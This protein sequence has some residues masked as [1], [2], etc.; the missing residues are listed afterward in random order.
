MRDASAHLDSDATAPA[1]A[2]LATRSAADAASWSALAATVDNWDKCRVAV[3]ALAAARRLHRRHG[4]PKLSSNCLSAAASSQ[5]LLAAVDAQLQTRV[6]ASSASS[7]SEQVLSTS[8]L[9]AELLSASP[10]RDTDRGAR[11]CHSIEACLR[12]M[13]IK[14]TDG[15]NDQDGDEHQS[16]LDYVISL[17]SLSQ[18]KN[19]SPNGPG[20]RYDSAERYLQAQSA[21]HSEDFVRDL[22]RDLDRLSTN[23]KDLQAL[24]AYG[25][26]NFEDVEVGRDG[27]RLRLRLTRKVFDYESLD[28]ESSRRLLDGALIIF[29]CPSTKKRCLGIVKEEDRRDL[30]RGVLRAAVRSME[31]AEFLFEER[32]RVLLFESSAYLEAF[33][34]FAKGL[35]RKSLP[36][37]DY[38][39]D[40]SVD[41]GNKMRCR[42]FKVKKTFVRDLFHAAPCDKKTA[43][44]VYYSLSNPETKDVSKN[45]SL[46][47]LDVLDSAKILDKAQFDAVRDSLQSEVGLVQGPPGTGKSFV[48]KILLCALLDN[49]Q[50]R[51]GPVLVVSQTNKCLD[52]LLESLLNR[53]S[54]IVRLGSRCTSDKLEGHRLSSVRQFARDSMMRDGAIYKAEKVIAA[55]R[56]KLEV[57]LER[58][59]ANLDWKRMSVEALRRLDS[60]NRGLKWEVELLDELRT[61]ESAAMLGRGGLEVLGATATGAAKHRCLV[62]ALGPSVAVVEEAALLTEP[63]L[64]AALPSSCRQVI[65]IGEVNYVNFVSCS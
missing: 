31:E 37:E 63:Q 28:W 40:A 8:R 53:T 9:I 52:S 2:A 11:L 43:E 1:A 32:D 41:K 55:R 38:F 29:Y 45:S 60:L 20:R 24:R 61:L 56:T 64:V 4:L 19:L 47:L 25:P 5:D 21:L 18:S 36:L 59:V 17:L 50:H 30:K 26:I 65:L 23:S 13:G 62:E 49:E 34:P 10:W 6:N 7:Y 54:R 57:E 35:P 58:S 16:C 48:G 15:S 22:R 42:E 44:Q 3:R 46:G 14:V 12:E 27:L 39:L 33:W 51:S